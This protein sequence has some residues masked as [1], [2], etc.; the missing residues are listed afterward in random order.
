MAAVAHA[1]FMVA[2]RHR[3]KLTRQRHLPI[4]VSCTLIA[5]FT[6]GANPRSLLYGIASQEL[7]E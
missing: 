1:L 6:A 3:V 5:S 2:A 7:A 4:V